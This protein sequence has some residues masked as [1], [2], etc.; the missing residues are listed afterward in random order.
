MG[1]CLGSEGDGELLHR[2]SFSG[3]IPL[4]SLSRFVVEVS[5]SYHQIVVCHL[6]EL[7]SFQL[8]LRN[9]SSLCIRKHIQSIK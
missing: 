4:P 2:F 3:G 7:S 6:D 8:G 1:I 9:N 5:L